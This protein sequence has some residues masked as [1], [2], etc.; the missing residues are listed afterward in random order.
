MQQQP[1]GF[2]KVAGEMVSIV[3]LALTGRFIGL[4]QSSLESQTPLSVDRAFSGA[5]TAGTTT[6][7]AGRAGA[8]AAAMA[9]AVPVSIS[10]RFI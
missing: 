4:A 3:L 1:S 9:A 2:L 7:A 5:G 6:A 10:L 8:A